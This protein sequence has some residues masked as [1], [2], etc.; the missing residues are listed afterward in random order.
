MKI[1]FWDKQNGGN[2]TQYCTLQ[3]IWAHFIAASVYKYVR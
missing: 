3:E 1:T 2:I